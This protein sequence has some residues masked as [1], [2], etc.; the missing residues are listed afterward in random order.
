[1]E[2]GPCTS[3]SGLTNPRSLLLRCPNYKLGQQLCIAEA[4]LS[5]PDSA[6]EGVP[7]TIWCQKLAQLY[8]N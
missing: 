4:D 6:E 2:L 8:S 1:M 7:C 5:V 3:Y